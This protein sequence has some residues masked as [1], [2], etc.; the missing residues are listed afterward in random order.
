MANTNAAGI[1]Y[2][3]D[4]NASGT[5]LTKNITDKL[6][7]YGGTPVIQASYCGNFANGSDGL[8]LSVKLDK[9]VSILTNFG[10]CAAS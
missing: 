10:L 2:L 1:N 4:S 8:S 3:A 7:T 9:I 6:S 5:S